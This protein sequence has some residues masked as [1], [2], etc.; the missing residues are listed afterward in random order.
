[1]WMTGP[2][3]VIDQA[4]LCEKHIRAQDLLTLTKGLY[5][6]IMQQAVYAVCTLHSFQKDAAI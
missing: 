1:M 4:F 6:L 5:F 2:A 3:S